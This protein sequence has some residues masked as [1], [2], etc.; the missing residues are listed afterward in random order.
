[1]GIR[2]GDV[3]VKEGRGGPG[4]VQVP[5]HRGCMHAGVRVSLVHRGVVQRMGGN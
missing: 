3:S 1:M 5:T 4:S 2:H